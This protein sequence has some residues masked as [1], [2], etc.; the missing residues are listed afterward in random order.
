L[1][2]LAHYG[3]CQLDRCDLNNDILTDASVIC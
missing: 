3:F 2:T 1:R